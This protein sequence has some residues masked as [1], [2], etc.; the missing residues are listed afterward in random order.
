MEERLEKL[1]N[2]SPGT[3]FIAFLWD[4]VII[5][6]YF[7]LLF[8][9]SFFARPLLIPLFSENALTAEMTGFLFITL[10]VYLYLAIGEGTR[11][12]A[13]WGKRKMGKG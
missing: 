6:S 13:T 3:R 12:H 9:V 8:G 4:Y 2:V 7:F 1:K 10:P 11:F 5:L